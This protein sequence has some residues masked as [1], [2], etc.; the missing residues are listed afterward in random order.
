MLKL[1]A[2]HL[3]R[4]KLLQEQL[5]LYKQQSVLADLLVK[6]VS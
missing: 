4:D 1:T 6:K 5:V 3:A 2:A